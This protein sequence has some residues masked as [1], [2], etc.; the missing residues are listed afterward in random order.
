MG[1]ASR[2]P[3]EGSHYHQ[4]DSRFQSA[5]GER[6]LQSESSQSLDDVLL[7]LKQQLRRLPL[8][9]IIHGWGT[10]PAE[11]FLAAAS[12]R[13][14]ELDSYILIPYE[15][16]EAVPPAPPELGRAVV[17]DANHDSHRRMIEDPIGDIFFFPAARE[18]EVAA[19]DLATAS[20]RAIFVKAGG[21]HADAVADVGR[22]QQT[23]VY[24]WIERGDL[25]A[26]PV[27]ELPGGAGA[28]LPRLE[29][30]WFDNFGRELRELSARLEAL[31]NPSD[32]GVHHRRLTFTRTKIFR[33]LLDEC[34]SREQEHSAWDED[35]WHEDLVLLADRHQ[36]PAWAVGSL[37]R[38]WVPLG[39]RAGQTANAL[40]WHHIYNTIPPDYKSEVVQVLCS[41][42]FYMV[43]MSD[44]A[45]AL[46]RHVT[47]VYESI[48]R[49][50]EFSSPSELLCSA[51]EF[52]N[53]QHE[54]DFRMQNERL[55]VS[56]WVHHELLRVANAFPSH[57]GSTG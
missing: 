34:R 10:P 33:S 49:E 19:A 55:R 46:V 47:L 38:L 31:P 28:A 8:T 15:T 6:E 24:F 7:A 25:S 39:E 30:P 40:L 35:R 18:A 27:G 20:A 3:D 26:P 50:R 52:A 51:V 22:K 48:M 56:S 41:G 45:A 16:S 21:E 37:P 17:L 44:E 5:P 32:N 4:P 9:T 53:T 54:R 14:H 23:A 13:L 42:Q 43:R 36:W 29:Q 12:A 2:R 57:H 11:D 1:T